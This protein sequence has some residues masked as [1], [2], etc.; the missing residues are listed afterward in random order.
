[1]GA[2]VGNRTSGIDL[3]V[4]NTGGPIVIEAG[5]TI[6]NSAGDAAYGAAQSYTIENYG[7]LSGLPFL[8][9]HGLR[10]DGLTL[11]VTNEID[12]LISGA[13][14][15]YESGGP[16]AMINYGRIASVGRYGIGVNLNRG[17]RV[18]NGAGASITATGLVNARR[19]G[20]CRRAGSLGLGGLVE[21]VPADGDPTRARKL[22]QPH[23]LARREF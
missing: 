15:V 7:T 13:Y 4:Y 12:G 21:R 5:D 14:G 9:G 18:S 1:M 2:I 8:S 6:S 19:R 17:G 11:S 16:E 22:R 20:A 3:F 10:L 23:D